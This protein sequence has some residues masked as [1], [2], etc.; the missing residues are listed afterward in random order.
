MMRENRQT[1]VPRRS[2]TTVI[3]K[4]KQFIHEGNIRRVVVTREER[5]VAQVPLTV[6][7]I[8]AVVAPGLAIVL[9]L[10]ALLTHSSIRMEVTET[11]EQPLTEM[12]A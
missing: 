1:L 4:I 2:Y 11:A 5:T 3:E 10:A 8:G 12:P 7:V 6:A 9:A